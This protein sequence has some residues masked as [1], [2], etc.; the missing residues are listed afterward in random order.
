[1]PK[2]AEESNAA[3]RLRTETLSYSSPLDS[4]AR[5][6]VPTVMRSY[7]REGKPLR[8]LH[9]INRFDVGG[10][11]LVLSKL[12]RELGPTGFHQRICTMHGLIPD[13]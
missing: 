6:A 9:V 12:M 5:I 2:L 8:V 4:A 10:M 13:G 11:E 3:A 7:R 1:M